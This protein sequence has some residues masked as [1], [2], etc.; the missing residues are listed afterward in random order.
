M[1][2]KSKY[3]VR[4][5]VG[6][7]SALY[8]MAKRRKAVPAR[9]PRTA[10]KTKTVARR[11]VPAR[12]KVIRTNQAGEWDYTKRNVNYG[13]VPRRTLAQAFKQINSTREVVRLNLQGV[14]R[15]GTSFGSYLLENGQTA[16]GATCVM[17]CHLYDLTSAFNTNAANSV[18]NHPVF[19]G[20]RFTNETDTANTSWLNPGT[21]PGPPSVTFTWNWEN[22]PEATA[23][24]NLNNF[25]HGKSVLEWISAKFMFYAPLTQ[26][27]KFQVD[28]IQLT[29]QRLHPTAG[30][31][32]S[33]IVVDDFHT[34]FWQYMLS[35]YSYNPIMAQ[36][37]KYAK[38]VKYL[39]RTTLYVDP[40]ETTDTSQ[41]RYKELNLFL[42]FNRT[43]NYKWDDNDKIGIATNDIESNTGNARTTVHPRARIYLM[44]RA[45]AGFR[46]NATLFS[47]AVHPS[48]DLVLKTQ[49]Q[50]CT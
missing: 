30:I 44:V 39:K 40:K 18:V 25:P 33:N 32:A 26:S 14:K 34:G 13:R 9:K 4:A 17:P 36:N 37:S 23:A 27:T 45:L 47:E 22:T 43:C 16:A 28:V 8:S 35:Q 3:A 12:R 29:D 42:R 15:F 31:N 1:P 24:G 38:Y 46:Q 11:P 7:A 41:S 2:Y 50:A 49:H 6:I 20:L 21:A 5:G 48:Y 10:T 19:Q